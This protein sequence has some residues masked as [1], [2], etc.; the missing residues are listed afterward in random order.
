MT[1]VRASYSNTARWAHQYLATFAPGPGH[2]GRRLWSHDGAPR[3]LAAARALV[4]RAR[5]PRLFYAL[6]I[7]PDPDTEDGPQD[8]DLQDLTERTLRVLARRLTRPLDWVAAEDH[9]HGRWRHVHVLV[10]SPRRL[11]AAELALLSW[12]ATAAAEAQRRDLDAR[13]RP[14]PSS[15]PLAEAV[16]WP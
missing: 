1:I 11:L 4:D 5:R 15:V 9:E 14:A 6:T 8:L 16:L 2:P 10:V 7:S 13:P 3:S 12:A